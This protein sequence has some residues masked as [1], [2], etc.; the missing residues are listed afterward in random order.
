MLYEKKVKLIL[1]SWPLIVFSPRPV[2]QCLSMKKSPR[3]LFVMVVYS[4]K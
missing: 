3:L 1:Y 4:F 2:Y